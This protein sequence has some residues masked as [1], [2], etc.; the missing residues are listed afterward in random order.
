M[1]RS[2]LIAV[3][4]AVLLMGCGGGTTSGSPLAQGRD[5]YGAQCSA[6]HG[7]RGEGG[8]GP[9]LRE[10][11]STFP[12]CADHIEWVT[13]GSDRWKDEHG[14]TRGATA[15]PVEG[16]MPSH[17]NI[18]SADEIALVAAFERV[19]YGGEVEDVT[20]DACGVAAP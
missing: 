12:S 8:T 11:T 13:L 9:S 2:V 17:E 3:A 7:S 15:T 19:T 1:P 18:L 6:C 20:L 4:C 16:G 10:V 5:V 14:D